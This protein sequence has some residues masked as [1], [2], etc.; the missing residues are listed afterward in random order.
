MWLIAIVRLFLGPL[1]VALLAGIGLWRYGVLF[2]TV[3]AYLTFVATQA[4]VVW[5]SRYQ[6]RLARRRLDVQRRRLD[7]PR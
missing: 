6:L 3:G 2:A 5:W 4:A 7:R 1:L